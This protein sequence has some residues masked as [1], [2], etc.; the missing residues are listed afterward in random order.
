M[1]LRN[2]HGVVLAC[3]SFMLPLALSAQQM[4]VL[5]GVVVDKKTS[6]PVIGAS[7]YVPALKRGTYTAKD[8][9]FRLPLPRQ[10]A[11]YEL[12]ITSVGYE[13]YTGQVGN[14]AAQLRFELVPAVVRGRELTITAERTAE[15]IVRRAAER[16][17]EYRR[18]LNTFQGLLYSKFSTRVEGNAFGLLDDQDRLAVL[19]TFSHGYFDKEKGHHLEI[20]QRRQTANIPAESNLLALGNF[21]S[22]YDDE[23]PLLNVRVPTPLNRSTF[24]RYNFSV[25]ERTVV[26]DKDAF[27]IDVTPA[28]RVLPAFQGTLTILEGTFDLVEADLRPSSATAVPFVTSLHLL[29]K[30]EKMDENIWQPTY[31]NVDGRADVEV[32]K[33]LADL[34]V[35][36]DIA[37]TYTETRVNESI[38]DSIYADRTKI[39]TATAT[40]DSAR[41]EFWEN[42]ALSKLSPEEETI[43]HTVDSLVA[44]ADTTGASGENGPG[45][46]N[47]RPY[48]DFNR[49]GSVSLGGG[50]TV[51][52]GPV[53]LD[54]LGYYSFG[55]KKSGGSATL[56]ID[57]LRSPLTVRLTGSV[58]SLLDETG[59]D[60]RIPRLVNSLTSALVHRDYYDYL[61]KDGWSAS[62]IVK[63][64]PWD[65]SSNGEPS[66]FQT[67][68][69]LSAE[70]EQSRQFA[71]ANYVSRSIFVEKEFRPNPAI[72][73]GNFRTMTGTLRWGQPDGAISISSS[74]PIDFAAKFSGIIGREV[75]SGL[76]FKSAEGSLLLTLPTIPTGYS[77]MSLQL[78]VNGGMGDDALPIQ[79]QFRM[80]TSLSIIGGFGRFYSAPIGV[81]GGTEYLALHAEHNFTD[82]FWRW[83]GLPT[84]VGRGVDLTVG[85]STGRFLQKNPIG[86]RPTGDAWY[87]EVGFGLARIPTFVSNVIFLKFDARW[88][89]GP[90]GSGKF[91]MVLGISS[92][93]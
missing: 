82:I 18:N 44:A 16:I 4:V 85:A 80:P 70:Y 77:P 86:Y 10:A 7:I 90:V 48:G 34:S 69:S 2:L 89:I 42:N 67:T 54:L 65:N 75:G 26:G 63:W 21:V 92:P 20:I 79:Y 57:P 52:P 43:Y 32:I 62:A 88:G 23:I 40:A 53:S 19:E 25:R 50:L 47:F 14:G 5:D 83:L 33:G 51:R 30:F 17:E 37:S 35:T 29:Q 27:I 93:F 61:R 76:D 1:N 74:A 36:F 91:G 41:P 46:F 68:L 72:V 12:R 78:G 8:G 24:S 11:P 31:L 87:S 6:E 38:P 58:F 84:Y 71:L 15:G 39:I 13:T 45:I 81:Y 9:T 66:P 55:M 49:V 64:F 73:E 3:L 60:N 22:F 56:N 59:S 28:T